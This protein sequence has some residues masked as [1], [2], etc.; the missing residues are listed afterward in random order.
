VLNASQSTLGLPDLPGIEQGWEI[1][2]VDADRVNGRFTCEQLEK[3]EAKRKAVVEAIAEEALGLKRIA[4]AFGVSVNTVLA[5]KR[6]YVEEI[7]TTKQRVGRAAFDVAQL[8]IERMRDEMDTMPKASLP[9][10]AGVMIDKGQLLTGAPTARVQ[11]TQAATPE[12]FN[13]WLDSITNV[14]ATPVAEGKETG[15]KDFA[16]LPGPDSADAA[17]DSQSLAFAPSSSEVSAEAG[18]DRGQKGGLT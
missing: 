12:S 2:T 18:S 6:K 14:T 13:E 10:I 15:Q 5:A 17:R 8:A 3:N 1:L 16:A 9:I 11:H 7:E 4:T